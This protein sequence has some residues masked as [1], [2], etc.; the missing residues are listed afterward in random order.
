MS[1]VDAELWPKLAPY[2]ILDPCSF[3]NR[4]RINISNKIPQ[5]LLV[6]ALAIKV[7]C[8]NTRC[9]REISPIRVNAG[10]GAYYSSSCPQRQ[11]INC[12]RSEG[13]VNECKRIRDAVNNLPV[14]M[15]PKQA[16]MF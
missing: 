5:P 6:E 15:E 1:L 3:Q 9:D 4:W 12:S 7:K 10:W 16:E 13:A 2:V 14:E 8:A 11:S